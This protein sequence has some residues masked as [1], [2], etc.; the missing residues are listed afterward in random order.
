MHDAL[1]FRYEVIEHLSHFIETSSWIVPEVDDKLSTRRIFRYGSECLDECILHSGSECRYLDILIA[2]I[3]LLVF[4]VIDSDLRSSDSKIELFGSTLD[5]Q[6]NG[7][8]GDS[9][10]LIYSILQCCR[11]GNIR[12]VDLGDDITSLQSARLGRSSGHRRYDMELSGFWHIDVRA[13]AVET[14][15]K[16]IVE[17][18]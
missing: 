18:F 14:S 8:T 6:L 1:S 11:F 3:E 12:I 9:F 5:M 16:L 7:G 2:R 10:D 13:Y 17:V 4:D 15:I